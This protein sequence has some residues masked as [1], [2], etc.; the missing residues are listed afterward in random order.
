MELVQINIHVNQINMSSN[1]LDFLIEPNR[2]FLTG[3]FRGNDSFLAYGLVVWIFIGFVVNRCLHD[4][5][6][7]MLCSICLEIKRQ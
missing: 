2:F 7:L 6:A 1:R 5:F 4:S 3:D